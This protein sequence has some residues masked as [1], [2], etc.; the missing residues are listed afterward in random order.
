MQIGNTTQHDTTRTLQDKCTSFYFTECAK[1]L[2]TLFW[3]HLCSG[4]TKK[5]KITCDM[6]V[7]TDQSLIGSICPKWS[8]YQREE[9][10][11]LIK[12]GTKWK[13][14]AYTGALRWRYALHFATIRWCLPFFG[15]APRLK[16]A[17]SL[18]PSTVNGG[19]SLTR[20][21]VD[22]VVLHT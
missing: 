22:F 9:K 6:R 2:P 17:G 15:T 11:G 16:P 5:K 19:C 12:A 1:L 13:L 18:Q 8:L 20:T 21:P 14:T 3:T 7:L 4:C 10:G